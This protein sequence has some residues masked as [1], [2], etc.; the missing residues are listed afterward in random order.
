M[1]KHAV[2]AESEIPVGHKKAVKVADTKLIVYHLDDGFYATQGNCTHM[3]APL[4]RGKIVKSCQLRCPIHRAH[5]DIRTGEVVSWAAFP[6]GI[7]LLNAV[8]K[9]KALTTYSVS[10]ED[11][12]VVVEV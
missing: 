12:Q 7:Q 5:F 11:G 1:S 8:R 6:P 10:V 3:G 9:E 4:R 2:C